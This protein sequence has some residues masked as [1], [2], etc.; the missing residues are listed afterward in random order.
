MCSLLEKIKG[1]SYKRKDKLI[2]DFVG[3]GDEMVESKL[4]DPND[5]IRLASHAI[6]TDSMREIDMDVL[7]YINSKKISEEGV[8]TLRDQKYNI[9]EYQ[10]DFMNFFFNRELI[11]QSGDILYIPKGKEIDVCAIIDKGDIPNEIVLEKLRQTI[12]FHSYKKIAIGL[13][14]VL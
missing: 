14:N 12:D 2:M 7:N 9:N 8:I 3:L 13:E 4:D 10:K 11:K 6:M 5:I 1:L